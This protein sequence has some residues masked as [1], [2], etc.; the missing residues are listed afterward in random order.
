MAQPRALKANTRVGKYAIVEVVD[1]NSHSVIYRAR[2]EDTEQEFWLQEY[3]PRELA[4]RHPGSTAVQPLPGQE[5]KF[6]E[7]LTLFL[8]EARILSQI[9]EPYLI[10]V[11]EYAEAGG[12][13]FLSMDLESGIT[14]NAHLEQHGELAQT[15]LCDLF[16]PLLKGLRVVHS[17]GLLHRDVNPENIFIRDSG[18]PL[19]F[20]FGSTHRTLP[21]WNAELESRVTPGYS[22]IEQYNDQGNLGPWTDLYAMGAVMYRCISGRVPVAANT[23]VS[24]LTRGNPDPLPSAAETYRRGYDSRILDAVDRLMRPAP[25]DRPQSVDE[26][27]PAFAETEDHG[28]ADPEEAPQIQPP[29]VAQKEIKLDAPRLYADPRTR[30]PPKRVPSGSNP[31]FWIVSLGFLI[32]VGIFTF[33]PQIK[34]FISPPEREVTEVP[35]NIEGTKIPEDILQR[36][37]PGDAP[38]D[39]PE[40]VKFTRKADDFRMEQYRDLDQKT[41]EIRTLL[42]TAREKME[43]GEMIEPANENA[44]A[45]FRAVLLLDEGNIDA[46][47]GID[48]IGTVLITRAK[49]NFE[50]GE[51]DTAMAILDDLEDSGIEIESMAAL[52]KQLDEQIQTKLAAEERDRQKKLTEQQR[53]E[54]QQRVEQERIRLE[55]LAEQQQL[56]EQ[57]PAEQETI[58]Q[59]ENASRVSA[60]LLQ[61]K[62]AHG[63]KALTR[64][65]AANALPYLREALS[66]DPENE[67]ALAGISGIYRYYVDQAN[68]ALAIDRFDEAE[69]NL[70][71]AAS[72]DPESETLNLL[73]EQ[74]KLRQSALASAR[75]QQ[76]AD[77][78]RVDKKK[79]TPV[80][81][82]KIDEQQV[83]KGIDAYYSGRYETAYT[84]LKPLAEQGSTRAQFRLG[85]MYLRGRGVD[86]NLDAGTNLIKK[87]FPQIQNAAVAGAAW[88]Q[89]DLGS[90]YQTGLL[91]AKNDKEAVRWYRAAA[92]QGYAGAQT[93]LGAMYADGKG[94]AQ[95]RIEAVKWL[96]LAAEQGDK[97]ARD[98]LNALGVQNL[99]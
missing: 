57:Q 38:P 12:T 65:S 76:R 83:A 77:T 64:S 60:L 35:S 63:G 94:V 80:Q 74:M 88:A 1:T 52:R 21:I 7:G 46:R 45:S 6:E 11:R 62:D 14:L 55:K 41:K 2:L 58:R 3:F 9:Q 73:R 79:K 13:A 72:I 17:H 5:S 75:Q 99:N 91:V 61:A 70:T 29:A 54:E 39:L 95:N 28:G 8:Q 25:Q 16:F 71:L 51:L 15:E 81:K 20:G 48:E 50:R 85:V 4:E 53:L 59:S 98:N 19:L 67:E 90:L 27:M 40:S 47:Q 10:R 89:A 34:P 43:R 23:R 42:D 86:Q 84:I 31:L 82:V 97:V 92:E 18:L 87:A 96:K 32:G 24:E 44:L 30:V 26:I 69:R 33:W 22:A 56:E 49:D 36:P 66:I 37:L 78:S 68:K 93:N